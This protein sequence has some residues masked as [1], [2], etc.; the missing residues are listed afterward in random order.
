M[1]LLKKI[2]KGVKSIGKAAKSVLKPVVQQ[3]AV[4][5]ATNVAGPL[6]GTITQ[7]VITGTNPVAARVQWT[8]PFAPGQP[9]NPLGIGSTY[10]RTP[11][12]PPLRNYGAPSMS[13]N[14]PG[15]Q[16]LPGVGYVAGRAV[17]QMIGRTPA[18]L[19]G[20]GLVLAGGYL[21]DKMS[22]QVVGKAPRRRAKGISGAQLKA[23][24]RVN[25]ML[26]KLC[27]TAPPISRRGAPRRSKACR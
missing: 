9:H 8:D 11:M 18:G 3:A 23:F 7:R 10:N 25:N 19:I 24:H 16:V 17:G 27:K 12:G 15:T 26:N 4:N 13:Q 14:K 1:S 6:A 21:I 20:T 22:G 2:K 5:L